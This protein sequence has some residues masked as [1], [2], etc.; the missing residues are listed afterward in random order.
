MTQLGLAYLFAAGLIAGLFLM[1]RRNRKQGWKRRRAVWLEDRAAAALRT[2]ESPSAGAPLQHLGDL[3][4][5][6]ESL[7][8]N[9]PANAPEPAEKPLKSGVLA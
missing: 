6:H 8:A 7:V 2:V 9:G 4:R 3:G 1:A 5:L